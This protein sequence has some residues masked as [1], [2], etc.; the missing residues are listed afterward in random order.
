[1]G[2]PDLL[3]DAGVAG[4]LNKDTFRPRLSLYQV[5]THNISAERL[6]IHPFFC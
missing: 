3:T 4:K 2:F 5:L 6:V 1:M